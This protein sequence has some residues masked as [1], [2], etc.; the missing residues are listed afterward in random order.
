MQVWF[1]SILSCIAILA[2]CQ[3]IT[4][5]SLKAPS[6]DPNL[7][8][9]DAALVP[10]GSATSPTLK[11]PPVPSEPAETMSLSVIDLIS[12][13]SE[14]DPAYGA[15]ISGNGNRTS[16]TH[17]SPASTPKIIDLPETFDPKG[18]IGFTP[19]ALVSNLGK[20]NMIRQEGNVEVWQYQFDSCVVDFFFYLI[21]EK[22]SKLI[23]KDWDMRSAI[24]G[25]HLDRDNC[26]NEMNLYHQKILSN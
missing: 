15:V 2:A 20:A 18:I 13:E 8:I 6:P 11:A 1:V 7:K 16:F 10:S 23:S 19:T 4:P 12:D 22:A 26:R 17:A 3:P 14:I 25:N 24:M 9:N 21:D 5:I